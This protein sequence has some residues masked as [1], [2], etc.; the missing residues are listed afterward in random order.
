MMPAIVLRIVLA[1]ALATLAA[2]FIATHQAAAAEL[3]PR[4]E[5]DAAIVTLGDLFDGAG[6]LADRAV[7][8]APE[9]GVTGALPANEAVKAAVAAGLAV[10]RLPTFAS[11]TVVRRAVTIDDATLKAQ[12]ADAAAGRLGATV[13]TIDVTLDEPVAPIIAATTA[14]TPIALADFVLQPASGR[15]SA[16]FTVDVGDGSHSVSLTGRAVETLAIPMLNRPIDRRAVIHASDVTIVRIEKRRVPGSAVID[17]D[18]IVDMA[19]K[20]PLRAG[21]V[22]ANSDVEPPR[23]IMRG[24]LVTLQYTRPGLTLSAR[25]R[26]LA[27]GAKGDIVSVLNEQSKRTIQGIVTGA[28]IVSV[29]ASS[30]PAVVK[31]AMN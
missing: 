13:D 12:V 11:V 7:F 14:S 20:R 4:V 1:A 21:E 27:D 16:T 22:I 6:E 10:D 24:D 30:A 23:V 17:A 3:R 19:A 31:T 26:A 28:G 25:G 18:E 2:G 15:F 5:I 9:L 29:T 8:R